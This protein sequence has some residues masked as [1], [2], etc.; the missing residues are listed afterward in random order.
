MTNVVIYLTPSCPYC[1]RAKI[2]LD[3]KGVEYTEHRIDTSQELRTEMIELSKKY[4]VPQIFIDDFH[5]GGFDDMYM[6]ELEGN[7]DDLLFPK[8]NKADNG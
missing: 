7:L 8:K 2:L 5:V 6:M 4:S 1:I 3:K